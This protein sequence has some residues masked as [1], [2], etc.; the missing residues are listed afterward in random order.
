[1]MFP[2]VQIDADH[3]MDGAVSG[4]TPILAAAELGAAR[5]D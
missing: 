4:N 2:S 1:M 3:L 5:R